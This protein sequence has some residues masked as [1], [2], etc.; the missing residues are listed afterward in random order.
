MITNSDASG[1]TRGVV[2][3]KTAAA[4]RKVVSDR[5]TKSG[6]AKSITFKQSSGAR[7]TTGVEV[8]PLRVKIAVIRVRA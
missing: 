8:D 2:R 1:V 5:A 3:S 4:S 6:K 7:R